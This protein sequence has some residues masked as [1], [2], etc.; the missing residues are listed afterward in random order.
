MNTWAQVL[1]VRMQAHEGA[2]GRFGVDPELERA[3]L[4]LEKYKFAIEMEKEKAR[5]QQEDNQSI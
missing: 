4:E 3:R 1:M 5:M 2:E